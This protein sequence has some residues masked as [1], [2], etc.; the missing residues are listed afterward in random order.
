[1]IYASNFDNER[2]GLRNVLEC[3]HSGP[4]LMIGKYNVIVF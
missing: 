2:K 4:F 1:M 3:L